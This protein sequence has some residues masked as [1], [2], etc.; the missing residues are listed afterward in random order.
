MKRILL[1]LLALA[2]LAGCGAENETVSAGESAPWGESVF[3]EMPTETVEQADAPPEYE[4][5]FSGSAGLQEADS[6]VSHVPEEQ[7]YS[8]LQGNKAYENG[9]KW[10]GAWT[11][12]DAGG[13]EFSTFGCGL[14]CMANMYSTLTDDV[15]TPEDIY[16]WAQEYTT[17][18]PGPG[19]GAID[20]PEIDDLS[21]MYGFGGTLKQKPENYEVFQQDMAKAKTI[22]VLVSSEY[23]DTIW[24]N[25]P[26]HY[27]NLWLYDAADDTVFMTDSRG[28][29]T[30]RSRVALRDV[31]NALLEDDPY[32]YYLVE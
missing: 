22:M 8:Y 23:D 26:G 20:W 3:G 21:R 4:A 31:Y 5:S 18:R 2:L 1:T 13:R 7:I 30:N 9:E 28:P 15:C 25:L 16:Y 29:A 11:Y 12:I 6:H 24:K 19:G 17:Y 10:A 27:V 14:C 32:Q